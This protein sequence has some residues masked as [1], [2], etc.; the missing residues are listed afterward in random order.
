MRNLDQR[1]SNGCRTSTRPWREL[2]EQGFGGQVNVVRY[3]LRQRRKYRTR[4]ALPPQ[5]PTLR[6]SPRQSSGSSLRQRPLRRTCWNRC[7][8]P[9]PRLATRSLLKASSACSR[10]E[11]LRQFRRGL[12]SRVGP[13]WPG[14]PQV[15][16]EISAMCAKLSDFR[17][18]KAMSKGRPI[19]SSSS[20]ARCLVELASTSC[21]CV[22]GGQSP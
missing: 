2:R 19:G 4:A 22:R 6:A 13:C 8:E 12:K 1:L 7:I 5:R 18:T 9:D 16:N 14:S 3:W 11:I 10:N 21:A 17:G 15:S 20:S